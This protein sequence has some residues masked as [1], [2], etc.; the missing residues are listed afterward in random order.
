MGHLRRPASPAAHHRTATL[1]PVA[2][3]DDLDRPWQADDPGR[4]RTLIPYTDSHTADLV[5]QAVTALVS[6]RAPIWHHDPGPTISA[7]VSLAAEADHMVY[8]AVA[9]AR[10]QG[11]TWEQIANRLAITAATARRRHAGHTRTRNTLQP[12]TDDIEPA[13][14]GSKTADPDINIG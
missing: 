2:H 9:D 11:Y 8:D 1:S 7:L 3:L 6:A 5:D 14:P 10:D 4:D 12:A 13:T